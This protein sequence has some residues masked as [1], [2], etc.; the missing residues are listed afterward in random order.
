MEAL[1]AINGIIAIIKLV[2]PHVSQAIANGQISVDKQKEL[3][4]SIDA[5]R[6]KTAGQFAGEHWKPST[7]A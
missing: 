3:M 7:A 4:D 6:A 5:L 1:A 2:E